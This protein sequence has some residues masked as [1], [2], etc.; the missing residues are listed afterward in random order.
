M[1]L[2]AGSGSHWLGAAGSSQHRSG[3]SRSAT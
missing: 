3:R 2:R 1:M